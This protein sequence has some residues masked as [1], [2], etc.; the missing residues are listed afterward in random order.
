MARMTTVLESG[1]TLAFWFPAS[2]SSVVLPMQ[3]NAGV[4]TRS[5]VVTEHAC[6]NGTHYLNF[7]RFYRST[8]HNQRKFMQ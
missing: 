2:A 8:R 3:G 1:H 6:A 4:T 7:A 5:G